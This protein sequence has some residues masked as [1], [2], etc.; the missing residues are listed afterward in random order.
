MNTQD[1]YTREKVNKAHLQDI[2]QAALN[3]RQLRAEPLTSRPSR[4]HA[5][6]RLAVVGAATAVIA[7]VAA[8]LFATAFGLALP[9][10]FA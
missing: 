8:V 1:M 9:T 2:H 7:L 10:L 6:W 3:R 4:A 5:Y